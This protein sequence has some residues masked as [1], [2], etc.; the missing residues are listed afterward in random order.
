[1]KSAHRHE[2]QTNALA[3]RLDVAIERLRPYG[4]TIVGPIAAIVIVS[5]AWSYFSNASTSKRGEAWN[6]YHQAARA[7]PPN[8]NELHQFA[9]DYP[10]SQMQQMADITWADGQVFEASVNYL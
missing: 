9:Q 6:I 8:L 2:L 7:V 4:S 3:Q 5:L 1:M 10:G